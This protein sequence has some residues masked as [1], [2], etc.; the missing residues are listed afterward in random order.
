[1]MTNADIARRL[2]ETAALIEL[3]G[4]NAFRARAFER[5]A[6]TVKGAEEPVPTLAEE[7]RL[8]DLDGVGEG[9]AAEIE[10]L[11]ATGSFG[12]RDDLLNAVPTGLLD[13]LKVKGLGTKRVRQLWKDLGITSLDDLEAA[14][15]ADRITSLDGF[16]TKTQ[17]KILT[18]ARQLRAYQKRRRYAEARE[19]VRPVVEAL[20]AHAA[21]HAVSLAGALR[22]KLETVDAAD[23]VVALA[24][25]AVPD[26]AGD[27]VADAAAVHLVNDALDGI[28]PEPLEAEDD[29]LTGTLAGGLPLVVHLAAPRLFGTALWTA[30]G[31]EAHVAAF[32]EHYDT[33]GAHAH[34]ADLY[35]A[36]G[37]PVVP[38]ELREGT[39][40]LDAAASRGLPS[41]I[42]TD[43]LR[44]SLHNHST[45]SDGAHTLR[46]MAERAQ[47]MGL[48]YF[49]ICDHS[50]SLKVAGGLSPEEVDRQR[51]EVA[52]L[53]DAFASGD[54]AAPFRVFHGIE[55]DVLRDGALDYDDDVLARFDFV[56]A[57]VHVGFN[58]TE[59]EATERVVTAIHNPYT[60]IL[61][62][63]TGRLLLVREGYPLNHERVIEAC[64]AHGVAIELNANPY[65]LDMDW[66]W[67]RRATDAGVLVSINPDAHAM[68]ELANVRWGVAAAR[69]GWLTPAQCLNA[70]P[71]DAFADWLAAR[72]PQTE[73][74]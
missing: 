58:M 40:E 41:L 10:E 35:A 13:V 32:V 3:T 22:R 74:S 1:M 65:R 29:A 68:D 63:A 42:T 5:A 62:H 46:Q 11:V 39:G 18:N 4:G 17:E 72:R 61:G 8:T 16:G 71:L 2:R 38:P 27:G 30:T 45:Y 50:Q 9:L 28:V 52:A 26:D 7:D 36:A 25:D 34:E 15:E 24:D 44:G 64:A 49:G 47:A 21:V 55:S 66:R 23:L 60:T 12:T 59:D 20:E 69:K 37:L 67:I 19:A 48:E 53:N 70:K 57:S 73:A 31:N 51:E 6:R 33:P 14:A 43:D 54:G 56:V